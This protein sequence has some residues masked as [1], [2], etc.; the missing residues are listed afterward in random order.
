MLSF[1]WKYVYIYMFLLVFF[2]WTLYFLFHFQLFLS[3]SVVKF[4][5][6]C[7]FISNHQMFQLFFWITLFEAVLNG[8]GADFLRWSRTFLL[9]LLLKFLLIFLSIFFLMFLP[10]EISISFYEY[11]ICSFNWRMGHLYL[12][13]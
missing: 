2:Y 8:T 1:F 3:Y 11:L 7:N 9:H 5:L 10:K 4:W 13:I 12:F 6:F